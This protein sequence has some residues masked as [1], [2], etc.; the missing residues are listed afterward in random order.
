MDLRLK[1]NEKPSCKH[2]NWSQWALSKWNF[3]LI[4]HGNEYVNQTAKFKESKVRLNSFD[5]GKFVYVNIPND[6]VAVFCSQCF[7]SFWSLTAPSL[8]HFHYITLKKI[9]FEMAGWVNNDNLQKI[10]VSHPLKYCEQAKNGEDTRW[11]NTTNA[12]N[13][14]QLSPSS[15]QNCYITAD[16]K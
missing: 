9:R 5:W 6:L 11:K 16:I 2:I 3:D 8:I 15:S 14:S 13:L 10:W 4:K 12:Q 7:L 1:Q